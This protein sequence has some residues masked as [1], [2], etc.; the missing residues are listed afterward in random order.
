MLKLPRRSEPHTK[1]FSTFPPQ[2]RPAALPG[3]H[4]IFR[5]LSISSSVLLAS[6]IPFLPLHAPKFVTAWIRIRTS[7]AAW[8]PGARRRVM[9]SPSDGV[10]GSDADLRDLK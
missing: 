5:H 8:I 4:L 2:S 6:W 9:F 1:A 3:P 7:K 10:V